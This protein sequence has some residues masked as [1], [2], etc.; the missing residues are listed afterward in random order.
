M[1][2]CSYAKKCGGCRYQGIP[3]CLRSVVRYILSV[4]CIFHIIIEIK[5]MPY[6]V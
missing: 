1:E 6:L 2:P 3:Y 4:V 5:S